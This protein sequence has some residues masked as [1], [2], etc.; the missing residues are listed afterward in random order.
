MHAGMAEVVVSVMCVSVLDIVSGP[1][2]RRHPPA[3]LFCEFRMC[4]YLKP[5]ETEGAFLSPLRPS[6]GFV[7]SSH[8][9]CVLMEIVFVSL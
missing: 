1:A 3:L 7:R 6:K 5:H 9:I 2:Q 4:G 8:Y